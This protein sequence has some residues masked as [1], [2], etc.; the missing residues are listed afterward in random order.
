MAQKKHKSQAGAQRIVN[1]Q[2]R[3][4][5][6]I[7]EKIEVGIELVGSE[8]KSIRSGQASLAEGYARVDSNTLQMFLH[9]VHVAEYK[10]AGPH[11]HDPRRTR[12]LLAHKREIK[13][14]MGLLTAGNR[15]L[16][17]LAMYFSRGWVKLEL[18]VALGKS[19]VDKRQDMK[20]TDADKAI[21][22]AMTRRTI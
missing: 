20:R 16:V 17:P 3:H 19:K 13:R 1:R 2:A 8:V 9:D 14:I 12:K 6:Q 4:D 22:R 21:R 15:T 5:Y 10:Q 7:L 11:G 18:G